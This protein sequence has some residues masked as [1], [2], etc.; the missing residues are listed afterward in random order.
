MKYAP[1]KVFVIENGEYVELSY[2]EFSNRRETDISYKDKLFL[3][4]Q[5]CLIESDREHY[6]EFYRDKER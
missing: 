2:K 5:G 6:V 1:R 4:V 3:P